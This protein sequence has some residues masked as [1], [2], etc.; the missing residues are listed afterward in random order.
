[1]I[2]KKN[3]KK[4]FFLFIFFHLSMWTLVPS[5]SNENLPLDTIEAL[6]WG[7]NLDW[8]FD[9]HPPFSAFVVEIFYTIFGSNDWVYYLLSQIFVV[10]AFIYVWKFSNEIFEDKIYSLLSILVL[11]GIYFYNFTTPEFNV[12]ISQ[13]PF[14]AL[15]VYFFWRGVNSN[16]KFYWILFGIFSA[17]GFLSKYLFIYL[18]IAIFI[19]FVSNLRRYKKFVPN[20]LISII[21]SFLI[22]APHFIWL[23]KNDFVTIFYGLNRS[24]LNDANFINHLKNPAIF[25]IKQILI[26]TPFFIMVSVILKK[27][28]FRLNFKNRK[29]MFLVFINLIPIFLVLLTSIITGA[30]LRTMW[31]T[32]FY[33][34]FGTLFFEIF[35]KNLNLKKI[36]KFYIIFLFF[37]IL[38]PLAYLGVSIFDETKR[39]DYPGKEISR[40]IQNKW[41][42]NFTNEIKIVI[43][44]EWSAG[45]LSYH[46]YSRP[47]WINDLKNK[48]T[49]I[50]DDQGV[51]Y[52]GNPKVLKKICPGVFGIIQPVGYCMI[53]R[54]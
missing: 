16:K 20:Y 31:M 40:L 15:T 17:I 29:I 21:I 22:L 52:A 42:E 41:N 48:I 19:Y 10:V 1:M 47:I 2:A 38:S 13:L 4:I 54:K 53:G 5:I 33:L 14:W 45:N 34:F 28:K 24:G 49:K 37:F 23:F 3:I 25:F 35:R 32:P 30:K 26:L 11:S 36:K 50:T 44:D 46:L 9:K 6:A 39:T 18:L 51:I 43:G 27:L 8:G 7:S 12:N